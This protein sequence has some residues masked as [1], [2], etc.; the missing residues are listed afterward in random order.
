MNIKENIN[1]TALLAKLQFDDVESAK[2][3]ET[4]EQ[5]LEYIN[6]IDGLD[7]ENVSPMSQILE[8]DLNFRKD[9]PKDGLSLDAVLLN[10]PNNNGIFITVPK[11]I[12]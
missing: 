8:Y 5:I 12:E 7:L 1:K 3:E 4:F 2:I 10:A 9:V 6:I 11:A